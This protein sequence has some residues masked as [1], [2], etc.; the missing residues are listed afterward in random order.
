MTNFISVA[1]FNCFLLSKYSL[2][3]TCNT[4]QIVVMIVNISRW[5]FRSQ[6]MS[7]N[8][9][10]RWYVDDIIFRMEI[11]EKNKTS[12]TTLTTNGFIGSNRGWL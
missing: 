4:I 1:R 10:R 6:K 12:L 9:E 3:P 7:V 8:G 2:T 11:S 5:R